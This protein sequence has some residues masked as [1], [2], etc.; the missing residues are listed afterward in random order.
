[1]IGKTTLED[2]SKSKTRADK[3]LKQ[4]N[5]NSYSSSVTS[6]EGYSHAVVFVGCHSGYRW[7]YGIKT[8][9]DIL[10]KSRN[11]TAIRLLL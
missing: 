4:V 7:L 5:I 3:L 11:G 1:M 8:K 10:K 9:D 6:I 2:F